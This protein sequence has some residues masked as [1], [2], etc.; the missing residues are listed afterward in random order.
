LLQ[1]PD[2]VKQ[3]VR[4]GKL[5]QSHARALLTWRNEPGVFQHKLAQALNGIPSKDIE[6][7]GHVWD[8]RQHNLA[9]VVLTSEIGVDAAKECAKCIH[10]HDNNGS[11]WVC[12]DLVCLKSKKEAK[13]KIETERMVARLKK[14]QS[15]EI[16]RTSDLGWG[17]FEDLTQ[18]R[19]QVPG[20]RE[21]CENRR[22]ALDYQ[23]KA[24]E[25]CTDMTCYKALKTAATKEANKRRREQTNE[26]YAKAFDVLVSLEFSEKA[27]VLACWRTIR[28]SNRKLLDAAIVKLGVEL[29]VE[30]VM[31]DLSVKTHKAYEALAGLGSTSLITLAA[32]VEMSA[33]AKSCRD[34]EYH[35]ANMLDWFIGIE[36]LQP[37]V[38]PQCGND[39]DPDGT[40]APY[41]NY[42]CSDAADRIETEQ[43]AEAAK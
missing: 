11:G 29:D 40:Y 19:K 18:E 43:S 10:R 15:K 31:G 37:A 14:A 27:A 34:S 35:E 13:A 16:L 5:S 21:D 22:I 7:L 2:E 26:R 12:L 8:L 9:D 25:I 3:M 38:C 41:C 4:S 23:D 36:G 33:D 39:A 42:K 17:N 28:Y 30:A 6:K 20:C 24:I 1:L 32:E